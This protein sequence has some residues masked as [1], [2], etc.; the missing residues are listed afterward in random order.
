MPTEYAADLLLCRSV[1]V[2]A[3]FQHLLSPVLR[4]SLAVLA[5]GVGE[6][7]AD[8]A[9]GVTGLAIQVNG[10]VK[11]DVRE[12][13]GNTGRLGQCIIT[14]LR[15]V[16][17]DV[18]RLQVSQGSGAPLTLDGGLPRRHPAQRRTPDRR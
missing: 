7:R 16:A 18:V 11:A 4:T 15:L 17:A 1:R 6:Y 9:G 13:P 14:A 10:T 12:S 3:P 5:G 2:S 8:D